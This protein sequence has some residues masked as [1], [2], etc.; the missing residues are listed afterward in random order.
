MAETK[1]DVA[2]APKGRKQWD[3]DEWA[4]KAKAKDEEHAER[5]K[6]AEKAMQQ[7]RERIRK[8]RES[9]ASKVTAKNYDF[10]ARLAEVREGEQAER[11]RRREE[12]KRKRLER[13]EEVEL[14]RVGVVKRAKGD[15]KENGGVGG[16]KR[17]TAVEN[18]Q[19]ENE[20][21]SLMMGFGGF[22][23]ARKR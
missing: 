17:D 3:K 16:G 18:A 6:D 22:G 8:L 19:R 21:I 1:P 4:A 14:G 7:V 5:A 11:G 9:T 15:M 13:R 20:D 23:G 2:P 10:Q 12:R